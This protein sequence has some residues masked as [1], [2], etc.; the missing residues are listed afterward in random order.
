LHEG[1]SVPQE[2]RIKGIALLLEAIAARNLTC[3]IPDVHQ[4]R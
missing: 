2:V 3:E 4:L 1:P